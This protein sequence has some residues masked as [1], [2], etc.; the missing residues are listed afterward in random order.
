MCQAYTLTNSNAALTEHFGIEIDPEY[1]PRYNARPAQLL[2]VV[3]QLHPDELSQFYWGTIPNWSKKKSIAEKLINVRAESLPDMPAYNAAFETR[4][5]LIPANGFYAWKQISK[6][7]QVP[8]RFVLDNEIPF[9]FAGIWEEFENEKGAIVHTFAILTTGANKLV[10]ST[11]GRM[12]VILEKDNYEVWL[13]SQSRDELNELLKPFSSEKMACYAVGSKVN[14]PEEDAPEL[15]QPAPPA[16]QFGN[17][18]L[19]D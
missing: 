6:K 17:Y 9:A 13:K 8:Y 2:P 11:G 12:P 19:F 14:N 1:T 4:R 18:S 16:D 10:Q 5:C 3:T 15:I 7:G